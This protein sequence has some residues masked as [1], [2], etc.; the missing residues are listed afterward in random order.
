VL[1]N[2]GGN[3]LAQVGELL[4]VLPLQDTRLHAPWKAR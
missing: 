2:D 4:K 1:A 3:R